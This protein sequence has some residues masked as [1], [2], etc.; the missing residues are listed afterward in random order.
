[1]TPRAAPGLEA[2]GADRGQGE[3]QRDV[4]DVIA[5]PLPFIRIEDGGEIPQGGN[6]M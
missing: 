1:V 4:G 6:G 5:H 3:P 2:P